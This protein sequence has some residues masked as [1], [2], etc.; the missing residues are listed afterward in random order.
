[1]ITS[2][3]SDKVGFA[4]NLPFRIFILLI[5][6]FDFINGFKKLF[7]AD[8]LIHLLEQHNYHFEILRAQLIK[9]TAYRQTDLHQVSIPIEE[10]VVPDSRACIKLQNVRKKGDNPF[11]EKHAWLDLI[12][13]EELAKLGCALSQQAHKD[14]EENV[15]AWHIE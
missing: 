7:L 15:N 3:K 11:K 2:N 13:I 10:I 9:A 4:F 14:V 12:L 5:C 6:Q 8:M 1:M